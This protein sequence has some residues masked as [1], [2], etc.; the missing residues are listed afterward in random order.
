MQTRCLTC[1]TICFAVPLQPVYSGPP[2]TSQIALEAQDRPGLR[3][4]S[5]QASYSV[6]VEPGRC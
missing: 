3:A 1:F 5:G 6:S 4:L 2:F